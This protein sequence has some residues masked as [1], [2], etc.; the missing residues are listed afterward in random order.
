MP[1]EW[2]LYDGEWMYTA[3]LG[4]RPPY[5]GDKGDLS[6]R[7]SP[8]GPKCLCVPVTSASMDG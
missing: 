4:I 6:R 1:E 2:K 5:P 3:R 7:E 8:E